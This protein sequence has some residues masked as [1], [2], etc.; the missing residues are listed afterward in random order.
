MVVY[1]DGIEDLR[2]MS[3]IPTPRG[4]GYQPGEG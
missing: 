2:D 4:S 1:I 3:H